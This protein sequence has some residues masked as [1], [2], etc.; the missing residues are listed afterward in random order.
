MKKPRPAPTLIEAIQA[1]G[2]LNPERLAK[3]MANQDAV[4]SA[5]RERYFH[6]NDLLYRPEPDGLS[7]AEWWFLLKIARS[8]LKQFVPLH[9][10]EGKQ[11]SYGQVPP[12]PKQLHEI[13][14]RLGGQI[15]MPEEVMNPDTK[16][17][18]YVSSLIEE[19]ITSSQLEGATTTRRIAK[20]MLRTGRPPQDK[21]ER[22]IL[23]NY[24]TMKR[25]GEFKTEPLSKELIFEIHRLVTDETLDN[26]SAA[27]RFR[28]DDEEE[29]VGVFDS[30]NRLMHH[31]PPAATLEERIAALCAFSNQSEPFVHPVI[32]SIILHFM[33]GYDHPF[34]DGNGR[35]AR[36][37]FY[38]SMLHH[39]YWLAEFISIS[40][41]VLKAPAQYARAYL[42]TET[43][44]GDLTYFIVHQL[45]VVM[46][47]LESLHD[48]IARKTREIRSLETELQGIEILNHRQRALIRHAIRHPGKRY[49][50]A[51]HQR[52]HNV[53]YESARSDLLDLVQRGL[54]TSA[55]VSNKWI[56]R[57]IE[58]LAGTLATELGKTRTRDRNAAP[59][60]ELPLPFG[61]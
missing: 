55:M 44:E 33:I 59:S 52:S 49:M 14:L 18:Y 16:D 48:Y 27:G 61:R 43:D 22:M 32:R 34:V 13:D 53:S 19:A 28:T 38:W 31:P 9:D 57:P 3:V 29:K 2:E 47:A 36:A 30:N 1:L 54:L 6:W 26:P 17:D 42:Y 50:V 20:E 39:G 21:S 45:M 41:I 25:I 46:R 4:M 23:N 8:Q 56:F 5:A 10:K 51:E 37:L 40:Q 11:F 35:T 58:N 24:L 7:H 60:S 15:K 12:I